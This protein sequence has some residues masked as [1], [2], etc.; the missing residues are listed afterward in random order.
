MKNLHSILKKSAKNLFCLYQYF[1]NNK[2]RM[3]AK[4]LS[5]INLILQSL[6]FLYIN[7]L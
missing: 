7:S 5:L 3:Q 4:V 2:I 6:K 1:C